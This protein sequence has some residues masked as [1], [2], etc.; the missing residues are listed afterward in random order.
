MKNNKGQTRKVKIAKVE[1]EREK[2]RRKEENKIKKPKRE[3]TME[4]KKMA[5]E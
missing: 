2:R 4:I 1:G 3:K 5:E